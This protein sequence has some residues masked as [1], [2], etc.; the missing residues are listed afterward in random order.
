ML[1]NN[2]R[3]MLLACEY[4][5]IITNEPQRRETYLRTCAPSEDSDQPAHS[6]RLIRIFT[7]RKLDSQECSFFMRLR[8]LI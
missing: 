1:T 2:I 7:G 6:R 5:Y 3:K 8:R 4:E